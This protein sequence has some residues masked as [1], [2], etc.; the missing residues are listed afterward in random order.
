MFRWKSLSRWSIRLPNN[1][2]IN[3]YYEGALVFEGTF[4]FFYD[5]YVNEVRGALNN[6]LCKNLQMHIEIRNF[7]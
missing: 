1:S 4:L 2:V 3:K 7:E 5:F 6:L